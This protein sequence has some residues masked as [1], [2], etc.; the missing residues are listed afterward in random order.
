[1]PNIA[2][3]GSNGNRLS[4]LTGLLLCSGRVT[5]Q[6]GLSAI[7]GARAMFLLPIIASPMLTWSFRISDKQ[8]PPHPISIFKLAHPIH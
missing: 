1:M 6:V 4:D 2:C 7:A 3:N 8:H 5:C